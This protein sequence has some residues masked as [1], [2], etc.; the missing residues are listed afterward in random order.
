MRMR[1]VARTVMV[2]GMLGVLVSA[3]G[4]GYADPQAVCDR[5]IAQAMAVDPASDTIRAVGG[6]VAG[7]PSLEAWVAAAKQYPDTLGARL[8]FP[9]P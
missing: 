4:I 3:R 8:S 9:G 7:C 6:A 5:A 2:L 1:T